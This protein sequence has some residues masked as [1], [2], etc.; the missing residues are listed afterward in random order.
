MVKNVEHWERAAS[1]A[2]GAGLLVVAA[3]RPRGVARTVAGAAATGL[4]SRGLLG[5][6]PVNA[7][8]GRERLRDDPRRALAGPLGVFIQ[9]RVTIEAPADQLFDFWRNPSNLPRVL[10]H[11]ERV[12]VTDARR[13]HWIMR[14]PAG[15]TLEWDAEIINEVPGETIGWQS[16]PGADVASA[17]SVR[18]RPVSRGGTEVMVTMQYAPPAGRLGA[19]IARLLGHSPEAEVRDALRRLKQTFE[20][21]EWHGGD[22]QADSWRG[23]LSGADVPIF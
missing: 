4:V 8:I 16:L 23:P 21:G 5:Y 18:V 3:R 2:I 19:S 11:L 17:G 22:G 14:G 10:P 12:D 15:T 20:A 1:L 13:S 6:C 9:E 7:A